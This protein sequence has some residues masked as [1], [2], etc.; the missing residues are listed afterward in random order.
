MPLHNATHERYAGI[1]ILI[2]PVTLASTSYAI[3]AVHVYAAAITVTA[4]ILDSFFPVSDT[5]ESANTDAKL[6]KSAVNTAIISIWQIPVTFSL[7]SAVA[8]I[9]I[10]FHSCGSE[11]ATPLLMM[12]LTSVSKSS[13]S[14]CV[15][16]DDRLYFSSTSN[17]DF[18]MQDTSL[19]NQQVP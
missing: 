12:L 10:R 9:T 5:D 6:V 17:T 15:S 8:A 1:S 14:T 16:T 3:P 11:S 2:N 7:S 19:S 18:I 4:A 13:P